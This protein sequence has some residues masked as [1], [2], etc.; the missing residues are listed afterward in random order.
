MREA[1]ILFGYGD[2]FDE[3]AIDKFWDSNGKNY[4]GHN[5]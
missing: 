3:S 4:S 1:D 2:T 5:M